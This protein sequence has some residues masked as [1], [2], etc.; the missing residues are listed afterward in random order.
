MAVFNTTEIIEKS[1]FNKFHALVLFWCTFIIILDG[2][3]LAVYGAVLP[4]LIEEWGLSSVEAGAIGSYGLVG[5]MFGAIFFGPLADRIGRKNVIIICFVLF[6]IFTGLCGL[7]QSPTDFSIYRFIAGLGLGGIMPNVIALMTDYSP[8]SMRSLT[9]AIVLCGYSIGG[10][11][12]PLLSIYLIPS[13][14]WEIVYIV[15]AVPVL[16]L[17]LIWKTLP[18]ATVFLAVKGKNKELRNI[19]QKIEPSISFTDKDSFEKPDITKEAGIPV[20]QLFK[21]KRALSTS[22][23]W[24]AY[25]MC[26]LMIY[27][28]NTWL[29][30]LMVKAGYGLNSSLSFLIILHAGTIV[31]TLVIGKLADKYGSKKM[32]I[33]MYIVG[34]ICLILLGFKADMWVISLL[35]AVTGACTIGAQNIINAYVSQYYPPFLRSTALGIS[36][37][38]GRIGAILGPTIGGILLTMNMPI[39]I[40]FLAFA[41]PGVLAAIALAFVPVKRAYDHKENTKNKENIEYKKQAL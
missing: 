6:S 28:L 7:A 33:P 10:M 36:S 29:P 41:I 21:N 30:Q 38:V 15:A 40:N 23:F 19:M 34:T 39:Q 9:V 27:G 18:D 8:K 26:L 32:L 4:I 1:K 37:G 13:F 16:L 3:D 31:G 24:I 12:A 2:Y 14:G 25:F 35:V 20:V 11:L 5:V 17:P 22:M